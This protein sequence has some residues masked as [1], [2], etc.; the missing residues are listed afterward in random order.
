[1]QTIAFEF[2][3]KT[4]YV[5]VETDLPRETVEDELF[6]DAIS[7]AFNVDTWTPEELVKDVMSN[8]GYN[9]RV[10]SLIDIAVPAR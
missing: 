3:D 5:E 6:A 1:M 10:M 9:Y 2:E 7:Y 4:I 8:S